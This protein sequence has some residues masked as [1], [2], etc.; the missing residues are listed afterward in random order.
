MSDR[1]DEEYI[2]R[3]T[4]LNQEENTSR[5]YY[6]SMLAYSAYLKH[7]SKIVDNH[8]SIG[9]TDLLTKSMEASLGSSHNSDEYAETLTFVENGISEEEK[10]FNTNA[11]RHMALGHWKAHERRIKDSIKTSDVNTPHLPSYGYGHFPQRDDMDDDNAMEEEEKQGN[12]MRTSALSSATPARL[13]PVIL[14]SSRDLHAYSHEQIENAKRILYP[15][16]NNLV[17]MP[18]IPGPA[19]KRPRES[20]SPTAADELA[21]YRDVKLPPIVWVFIDNEGEREIMTTH[22]FD[23]KKMRH[24]DLNIY[25]LILSVDEDEH[26]YN[27]EK[28]LMQACFVARF[29]DYIKYNNKVSSEHDHQTV[30]VDR[31]MSA[32]SYAVPM[33]EFDNV[34]VNNP[35]TPIDR[36]YIFYCNRADQKNDHVPIYHSLSGTSVCLCRNTTSRAWIRLSIPTQRYLKE[37]Y[38]AFFASSN[39]PPRPNLV[40]LHEPQ[41]S[42]SSSSSSS[43]ASSGS[44]Q[45][46]L[47]VRSLAAEM[48]AAAAS[49]NK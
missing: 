37:N 3:Q 42:S 7:L 16:I 22:E 18:A 49:S 46:V 12:M 23:P 13:R 11:A 32:Y 39:S 17:E 27:V 44:V 45:P 40:S 34:V 35:E 36:I 9:R 15:F 41:S 5:K 6:Y 25:D 20:S 24:G 8:V 43:S 48:D 14:D 31:A 28:H 29:P 26:Y 47:T 30:I 21:S 2:A 33:S 4:K 10:E 19:A 38:K 1:Q